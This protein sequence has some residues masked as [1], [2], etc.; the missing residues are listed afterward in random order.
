MAINMPQLAPKAN[1]ES[2]LDK[3]AQ[4]LNIINSTLGIVMTV[5]KYLQ[6]RKTAQL[7]QQAAEQDIVTHKIQQDALAKANAP[8]SEEEKT[9]FTGQYPNSPYIPETH[10]ELRDIGKAALVKS[11]STNRDPNLERQKNA[12]TFKI[13]NDTEP[14]DPTKPIPQGYRLKDYSWFDE[15]VGK[16]L[17]KDSNEAKVDA[18]VDKKSEHDEKTNREAIDKA[19]G[20]I[21]GGNKTLANAIAKETLARNALQLISDPEI[22]K[23]QQM[24]EELAVAI[25]AELSGGS[26]P[27]QNLVK[28]LVPSTLWGNVQAAAQYIFGK[29]REFLNPSFVSQFQHTLGREQKFWAAEKNKYTS[30]IQH[31]MRPIWQRRKDLKEDFDNALAIEATGATDDH[32]S[33]DDHKE[34]DNFFNKKT[35]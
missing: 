4:G 13:F 14:Y 35:P 12:Q 32:V 16:R 30:G 22:I 1:E 8:I 28:N 7:Q 11:I 5:P 25:A 9:Q 34:L 20:I 24:T 31:G 10:G 33:S 6:D 23:T 21:R 15:S 29:P 18:A 19:L 2:T 3:I 17:V 26:Q 27:A